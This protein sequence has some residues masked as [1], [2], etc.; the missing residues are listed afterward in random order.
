MGMKK[1]YKKLAVVSVVALAVGC[2][3]SA[4]AAV[5]LDA[6]PAVPLSYAEETVISTS[7]DLVDSVAGV[8][9]L[10]D[11]T[12]ALSKN[13]IAASTDVRVTVTLS[14]GATF[15]TAPSA[16][17]ILDEGPVLQSF[18]ILD[19]G[20]DEST[21]T[22]T[23]NSGAGFAALV[24]FV[25]EMTDVN[26]LNHGDVT[27]T[28]VV[29]I[30]DNFGTTELTSISA[31]PYIGF[32]PALVVTVVP[33]ETGGLYD[34]ID[35][36]QGS[37]YFN[38]ADEDND[39][40]LASVQLVHTA[41][42]TAAASAPTADADDLISNLAVTYTAS[43][44]L[45]AFDQTGGSVA[46]TIGTFE[47]DGTTATDT[48]ALGTA[49]AAPVDVTFTI[50]AVN[51]VTIDDSPVTVSFTGT[52][53]AGFDA[54]SSTSTISLSP[55]AKNG[56]SATANFAL[57]PGGVFNNYVRISNT[58]GVTGTVYITLYEDDGTASSP[59]TLSAVDASYSD[60]LAG[61]ASSAQ[62]TIQQLFDASGLTAGYTG[63]LRVVAEGEFSSIDIQT[64]TVSLDGNNFSTF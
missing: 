48:T 36:T 18:N 4:F 14:N 10:Q 17:S 54:S 62:M 58:S 40:V 5:D 59:F 51:T 52:A 34:L 45:A 3:G 23:G 7:I 46:D 33:E 39:T 47:I 64:Y 24:P 1:V 61:Q 19:G 13:T 49:Y 15:A 55:L 11:M 42:L 35:V 2:A 20:L 28:V 25:V 9:G 12:F 53:T 6:S 22:F 41:R 60:A 16:T 31:A 38:D 63:K 26:V 44:G 8:G 29:S 32:D 56:S 27:A 43:N 50:P 37:A 30:A 21:V 57:T